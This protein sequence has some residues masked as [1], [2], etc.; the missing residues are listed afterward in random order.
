MALL[1]AMFEFLSFGHTIFQHRSGLKRLN[2]AN[3]INFG[4]TVYL[5]YLLLI[6]KFGQAEN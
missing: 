6:L 2:L 3:L 5:T 4:P 1:K